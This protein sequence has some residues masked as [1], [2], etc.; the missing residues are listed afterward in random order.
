MGYHMEIIKKVS[1]VHIL[2]ETN[3]QE[4][5]E[6]FTSDKDRLLKECKQLE[7]ESKKMQKK[8]PSREVE[9]RISNE[10]KKRVEQI[11]TIKF[12]VEQ[13]NVLPLGSKIKEKEIDTIVKVNIGDNWEEK[14]SNSE[15]VVKDGIII[16]I[17]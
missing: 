10:V 12:K 2:T 7:F 8:Y 3:K 4:L 13:L 9:E 14:S 5:H 17:L 11:E 16:D 15:I 1:I 6:K